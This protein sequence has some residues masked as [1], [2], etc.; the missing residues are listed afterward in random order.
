[1]AANEMGMGEGT[2]SKAAGMVSTAKQDFNRL[3]GDLEGQIADLKGKWAGAG[4]Q[5]FFILHQAWT[6]KQKMVVSALDEFEASLRGTEKDAT[7]VDDT[8]AV[9]FTNFQN[10]L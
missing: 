8:Q 9:N 4:G 1:M 6:D 5:A 3:S 10:R 7:N 2:L